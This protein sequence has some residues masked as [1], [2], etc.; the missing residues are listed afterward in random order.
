MPGE[1]VDHGAQ[2]DPV[3]DPRD[4]REVLHRVRDHRVGREVVLDRPQGVE[5]GLVRDAGELKLF[6]ED[7]AVTL[8]RPRGHGLATLLRFIAVPVCVILID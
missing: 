8:R 6:E 4:V 3:G 1:D 5:A 2:I 7:L